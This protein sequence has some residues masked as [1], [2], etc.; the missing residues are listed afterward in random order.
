M[1]S[2]PSCSHVSSRPGDPQML[3]VESDSAASLRV[4][5]PSR[6]A[7]IIPFG[8]VAEQ[9]TLMTLHEKLKRELEANVLRI[10]FTEAASLDMPDGH[11][12]VG[13]VYVSHP[14]I[15]GR[16]YPLAGYHRQVFDDK[17]AEAINLLT[18]LGA[19]SLSV[20]HVRGWGQK[21]DA[22]LTGAFFGATASA[23]AA[24]GSKT[25]SA[26][27]FEATYKNEVAPALP[28]GLLWYADEPAWQQIV[29][30]RLEHGMT[31]FTMQL[32]Y[33]ED[34]NFDASLK[35]RAAKASVDVS[36]SYESQVATTWKMTGTF[37]DK[38]PV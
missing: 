34:Q 26:V 22:N 5:L 10:G 16:Y 38:K 2:A 1:S 36:G 17:V 28:E 4:A 3:L 19:T 32:T 6:F 15:P 29:K 31:S 9:L 12:R 14:R 11:P 18:S 27:L 21:L 7:K 13:T 37:N 24:S 8:P 20:E 35:A 25:S 30:G 23:Q 33:G